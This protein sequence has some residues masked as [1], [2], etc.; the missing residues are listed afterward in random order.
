MQP[1]A[2]QTVTIAIGSQIP[3]NAVRF[4]L[5]VAIVGPS[6]NVACAAATPVSDGTHLTGQNLLGARAS[7]PTCSSVSTDNALYYAAVIPAGDTLTVRAVATDS[8]RF[9]PRLRLIDGCAASVCLSDERGYVTS[10]TAM[11]Y[12]NHGT[13]P[14]SVV[15]LVSGAVVPVGVHFDLAI[16]IRPPEI[17]TSCAAAVSVSD[18]T[19]LTAQNSATAPDL[20]TACLP[21]FTGPVTYY[22]AL[23]PAGDVLAVRVTPT[24]MMGFDPVIRLMDGCAATSCL[25]AVQQGTTGS[26]KAASYFNRGT[27]TQTVIIAVGNRIFGDTGTFDLAVNIAHPAG[28]AAC[29]TAT[30]VTDG[31]HLT[32]QNTAFATD[33]SVACLPHDDGPVLYYRLSLPAG[34]TVTATSVGSDGTFLPLTTRLLDACSATSCIAS[35]SAP[36][37]DL[38]ARLIYTN[39]GSSTLDL[40]LAVGNH[41]VGVVSSF[42]LTVAIRP[43]PTNVTCGAATTVNNGTRLRYENVGQATEA[44]SSA[45]LPSATGDVLYY[46]VMVPAGQ[47]LTAIA[48]P[49]TYWNAVLRVFDSC[50]ATVCAAQADNDPYYGPE[51]VQYANTSATSIDRV[52]AVGSGDAARTGLF[53]LSVMIEAPRYTDTNI[54]TS[55]DD[56]RLAPRLFMP[57]D[58]ATDGPGSTSMALPFSFQLVGEAMTHIAFAQW[59][60][61]QLFPGAGSIQ[62]TYHQNQSIPNPTRPNGLIA[63]LWTS[64]GIAHP[65]DPTMP[66]GVHAMSVG[67]APNRHYTIEWRNLVSSLSPSPPMTVQA[68]LFESTNVIEFHDCTNVAG[69]SSSSTVG[70]EDSSGTRGYQHS[71]NRSGAISNANAIRLTPTM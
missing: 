2:A 62:W 28:N 10:G 34:N 63:P 54:P 69:V 59:G 67:T 42:D 33:P 5:D 11:I 56:L 6:M 13:A 65:T 60:Y 12:T 55:C 8:Y 39:T 46:R 35:Y 17:T 3:G 57:T 9:F 31:S 38:T 41:D 68:K 19:M 27:T 21:T 45:C 66:A 53:D 44:R 36:T 37:T 43:P 48:T 20:P 71:F 32:S 26:S 23:V 40:I 4:D 49:L 29:A 22:S 47:V 15:L 16:G 64:L 58:T 25:A 18:G 52:I 30:P 14:R 61:A 1:G 70:L 51:V 7:N 24:P 50:G